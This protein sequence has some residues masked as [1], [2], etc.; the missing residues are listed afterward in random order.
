[1][2]KELERLELEVEKLKGREGDAQGK[3]KSLREEY[4]RQ[5]RMNSFQEVVGTQMAN[6]RAQ[7]DEVF[8]RLSH[9]TN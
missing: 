4:A 6:V 3:L 9:L 8:H 1:M 5:G 7:L 2:T